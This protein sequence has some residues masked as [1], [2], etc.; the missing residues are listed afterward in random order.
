MRKILPIAL[1]FLLLGPVAGTVQHRPVD[2]MIEDAADQRIVLAADQRSARP[3]DQLR[4]VE[5][6]QLISDHSQF[7]G[8]SA[9]AII[10]PQRFQLVGDNGSWTRLTLGPQ[11]RVSDV[12][13]R[14]LPTPPRSPQRKAFTD[15][16][17]LVYDAASG[18]SWVA[19][20]GI[21]QVWR[22]DAAM[23]RVESRRR[24]PALF[25]WPANG[26]PEAMMRLADGRTLLLSENADLDPR[27][28]E[29]LV[30]IGD[31]AVPGIA[32]MRFF[33]DA[34]GKGQVSD[35][36]TLPDGRVLILHRRL[37]LS[38]LFTT[39]LAVADPAEI[40]RDGVW[41]SQEIGRVPDALRENYEGVAISVAGDRTFVW[42]V[43]DHNFNSWQRSLLVK[44]ELRALSG[45]KPVKAP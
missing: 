8:F 43:S 18:K 13:I 12:T 44:F 21:N 34:E 23:T 30:Y 29:G 32:P 10:G 31:P 28:T 42:L 3:G 38:P 14:R 15:V 20:E 35:A 2:R 27:G 33:Y 45:R 11:G 25:S 9:L 22:L 37:A 17:A 39:I 4:F 36:A 16:E 41:R 26:G 19:L 1:V 24:S 6:W 7:G 40:A 5:G